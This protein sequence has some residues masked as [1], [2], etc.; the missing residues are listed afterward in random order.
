MAKTIAQGFELL[1][2]NLE[3]TSLQEETVSQRQK[4]VRAAIAS[5]MT[6]LDSFLTGSYRRNTMI[7]PLSEGD[8]DI[9]MVLDH[10]Y[11]VIDGQAKLLQE[12]RRILRKTYTRT[13]EISPTGQ[14]VTIT[15]T[16]FKV[17]VVLGFNRQ[18][19][20]YLIPN[21]TYS[22]WISTDPKKHVELWTE[23][24]K[25]HNG[26][27]VPLVKMIKGWNKAA[28]QP[29]RSFHL[30]CMVRESLWGV[31]VPSFPESSRYVL[32]QLQ[33]RILN[34]V[35]DPAGYGGDVGAYLSAQA[36]AQASSLATQGYNH[37]VKAEELDRH[38]WAQEAFTPWRNVF[39]SYFPAY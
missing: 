5:E 33:Q 39:G 22:R 37:A 25:A 18:G 20:G 9:F 8:V 19:G 23:S 12:V 27:F 3:I 17:D 24:N 34:P 10:T 11:Y 31:G 1:K 26:N 16:D 21:A 15:F 7:A 6:V 14:A 32:G 28:G 38:G 36:K 13:P 4:E 35:L 29:L 30:E 2:Q